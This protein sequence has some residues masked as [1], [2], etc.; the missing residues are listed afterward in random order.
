MVRRLQPD[1]FAPAPGPPGFAYRP[2]VISGGAE[3][4]LAGRLPALPF[5]PFQFRGYEGRRRVV[6]F[7]LRYDFNGAGLVKAAPI[8]DWLL[9][10][11]AIAADVAGV[12]PDAFAHLLVNEYTAGA[13]I[14]WHRDRAAF[15]KVVG[16]SLLASTLMRFRRRTGARFER[17][18][19][20]LEPRSAYL[21]DGPARC[22]WEHSL[23][24]AAALRY[25]LTFRTLRQ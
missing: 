13:P 17:I 19:V 3:E 5:E 15:G 2:D 21:L 25:S 20:P 14:G 12:S 22:E 7:G 24:P 1:L 18:S 9:P 8:P 4:E 10:L 23:P 16:I 6:S 11:R